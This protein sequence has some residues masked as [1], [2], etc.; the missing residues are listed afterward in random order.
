MSLFGDDDQAPA[1]PTP[2]RP[3]KS[4]SLFD[5]TTTTPTRNSGLFADNNTAT[6]SPWGFTSAKRAAR[7]SLVKTLLSGN[8]VPEVYVNVYDKLLAESGGS[9]V[10]LEVVR[11]LLQAGGVH[12]DEASKIE[13]TVCPAG[14]GLGSG[15]V[16]VLIAMVGL[17]QEGEEVS[18]DGADERRKSTY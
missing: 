2:S 17:A 12:G 14:Q 3:T 8:D 16:F 15:E 4:S 9:S 1:A 5:D 7:S 18:L 13:R 11:K 10:S 6:D